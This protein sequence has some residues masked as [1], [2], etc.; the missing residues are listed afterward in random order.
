[1]NP[2]LKRV[3]AVAVPLLAGAAVGVAGVKLGRAAG[4]VA[5]GARPHPAVLVPASLVA[6]YLALVLHEAG[7]V[8]GGLSQRFRFLFLAAG[9]LWL[10]RGE[11]GLALRWNRIPATWGGVAACVPEDDRDLVRRMA[12]LAAGGPLASL[13]LALAAWA[14]AALVPAHSAAAVVLSVTAL[15]SG[16]IF[17]ATAQPFGAGGGFMSDGGRLRALLGGGPRA[18][19]EAAALALTAASTAGVR[20]RDWSEAAV[21][22]LSA[23]QDG[24]AMDMGGAM[25]GYAWHLDRGDHPAAA[26]E[27]A[28]ARALAEV[29]TLARDAL[30]TEAAWF[31]ATVTGDAARAR[32][33]LP[34]KQGALVEAWQWHRARAAVLLAEGAR[35]AAQAEVAL[36]E[37]ALSRTRFQKAN[38]LDRETVTALAAKVAERAA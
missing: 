24:S 2:K 10:E 29:S 20:P 17:L 12:V 23:H 38:A 18:A 4:A 21:R 32:A 36:A 34:A 31:E 15:C 37:A 22:D 14:G 6:I 33:A 26:A 9:P 19:R 35:E 11:R 30:G 16:L 8:L 13:A 28:R 27:L 25:L 5:P 3:L 1:V 7:H